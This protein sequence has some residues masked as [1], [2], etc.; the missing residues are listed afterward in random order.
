[1]RPVRRRRAERLTSKVWG[2]RVIAE[3]GRGGDVCSFVCLRCGRG[4]T[5]LSDGG[6]HDVRRYASD[7]GGQ[8]LTDLQRHGGLSAL[9][10]D[11]RRQGRGMTE[12]G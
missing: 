7:E 1:M 4:R 10:D 5:W 6:G 9:H 3:P 12:G 2:F 11:G 8:R